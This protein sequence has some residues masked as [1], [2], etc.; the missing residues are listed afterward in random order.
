MGTQFA[1]SLH[2][3]GSHSSYFEL[4]EFTWTIIFYLLIE[5]QL[6]TFLWVFENRCSKI[7]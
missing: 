1:G 7:S 3:Q 2:V 5:K 4:P 6:K